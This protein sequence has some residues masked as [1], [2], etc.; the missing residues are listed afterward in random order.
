[1]TVS[2]LRLGVGSHART[3]LAAHTPRKEHG[4][5]VKK[6]GPSRGAHIEFLNTKPS[7]ENRKPYSRLGRVGK[8]LAG[9]GSGSRIQCCCGSG[10]RP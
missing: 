7:S 2:L 4:V 9:K 3:I 5:Q 8:G 10:L 6:H 1:M